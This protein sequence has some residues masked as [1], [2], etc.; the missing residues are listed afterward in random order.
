MWRLRGPTGQLEGHPDLAQSTHR[1]LLPEAGAADTDC[2]SCF[3]VEEVPWGCPS[4][5]P[6]HGEGLGP[7]GSP[8]TLSSW[9]LCELHAPG[10]R[11]RWGRE[12]SRRGWS[13]ARGIPSCQSHGGGIRP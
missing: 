1:A 6:P 13:K 2:A 3:L 4:P 5:Q 12:G 8:V 10:C 7:S 11:Y 9:L